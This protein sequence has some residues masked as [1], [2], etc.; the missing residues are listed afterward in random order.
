[1][2]LLSALAPRVSNRD[3]D[4]R[5]GNA[6]SERIFRSRP[7]ASTSI[8]LLQQE[9][10]YRNLINVSEMN[11]RPNQQ[12]DYLNIYHSNIKIDD[13]LELDSNIKFP[14][15]ESNLSHGD[16]L[17]ISQ[18]FVFFFAGYLINKI[19]LRQNLFVTYI[20]LVQHLTKLKIALSLFLEIT[21]S[22]FHFRVD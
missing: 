13:I 22:F 17:C 7:S 9:P 14:S 12:E 6:N 8:K 4:F 1:M 20:H 19:Q 2:L 11:V 10:T 18:H 5:E 3:V 16:N 15:R 21:L